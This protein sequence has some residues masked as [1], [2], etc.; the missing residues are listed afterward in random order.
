MKEV[1]TLRHILCSVIVLGMLSSCTSGI[2]K[3]QSLDGTYIII[4]SD[5]TGDI[6][7]TAAKADGFVAI[8]R[9]D[10]AI[11]FL[12]VNMHRFKGHDKAILL[13]IRGETYLL[14]DNGENAVTDYA[15]ACEADSTNPSYLVNL[16]TAYEEVSNQNNALFFA[17]K[18]LDMQGV[19]D[20]D[21]AVAT[22]VI[23]RCDHSDT[24]KIPIR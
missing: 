16:A 7:A 17:R 23:L 8:N 5:T 15:A 24:A 3:T 11:S 20:S 9:L 6:K 2:K 21:R 10:D 13:N 1:N 18:A 4:A 19:G 22:Q 14:K 12:S